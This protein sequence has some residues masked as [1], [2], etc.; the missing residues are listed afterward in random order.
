MSVERVDAFCRTFPG[1]TSDLKWGDNLVYSVGGKMFVL[2]DLE[3]P[4]RTS[5]K[6]DPEDFAE[7]VEREGIVPAPYLA[8]AGWVM[9]ESLDEVMD[10]SELS[11][12]LREA[13]RLV[14]AKLPRGLRAELEAAEARGRSARGRLSPDADQKA[15]GGP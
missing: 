10:W 2:V 12:R 15:K 8:R 14:R 1:V 3:L 6:C 4:Y 5:F 7:L 13:Y 9:V 11:R